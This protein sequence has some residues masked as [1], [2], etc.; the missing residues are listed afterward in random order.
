MET[1]QLLNCSVLPH[2]CTPIH[3][4]PQELSATRPKETQQP[5]PRV[6]LLLPTVPGLAWRA[7]RPTQ[8]RLPAR[9]PGQGSRTPS[10]PGGRGSACQAAPTVCC[11][12]YRRGANTMEE[13]C[14]CK[15]CGHEIAMEHAAPEEMR[16]LAM[17]CMNGPEHIAVGLELTERA[18]TPR[19]TVPPHDPAGQEMRISAKRL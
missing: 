10:L 8:P 2:P 17:G 11:C 12:P 6:L 18:E 19:G 4:C 1:C 7:G 16:W 15:C 13:L 9:N 14:S 3:S 5:P